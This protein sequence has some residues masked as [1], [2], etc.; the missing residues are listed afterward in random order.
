MFDLEK[1][2]ENTNCYITSN[3]SNIFFI[4]IVE[5]ILNRKCSDKEQD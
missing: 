5:A 4:S 2:T 3:L 1:S